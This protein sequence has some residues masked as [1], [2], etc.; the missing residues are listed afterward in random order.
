[1]VV[2]PLTP[3][4]YIVL[5]GIDLRDVFQECNPGVKREVPVLTFYINRAL[6]FKYQPGQIKVKEKSTCPDHVLH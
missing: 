6:K 5:N 1:V 2:S 3:R 4:E